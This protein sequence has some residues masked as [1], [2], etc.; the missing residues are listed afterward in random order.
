[1]NRVQQDGRRKQEDTAFKC[2]QTQRV[3]FNLELEIE[4][5]RRQPC[6]LSCVN[7]PLTSKVT[8]VSNVSETLFQF[9]KFF[10]QNGD[11]STLLQVMHRNS[12]PQN[13]HY[14]W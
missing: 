12:L 10:I 4:Q 11:P 2:S 8:P 5:A 9:Y 7:L 6:V 1:M 14:Y 3:G 13:M